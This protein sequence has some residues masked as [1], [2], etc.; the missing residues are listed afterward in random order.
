MA[1]R[2]PHSSQSLAPAPA[3]VGPAR[4]TPAALS[5]T[6]WSPRQELS[7]A[8]WVEQGRWL[9]ALGRGSG[10]WL[11][12]WLR[13]GTA[14]YGDK[15]RPAAA[16][17]GYDVQSL[18]NMAWVAGRFE[19]SRRRENLSF[20]HHAELAGL[21]PADQELWLDR[22]AAGGLSVRALRLEL[23]EARRR[24]ADRETL[25]EARRGRT[26]L[27]RSNSSPP[28]RPQPK[29][30]CPHCGHPLSQAGA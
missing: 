11:G 14:R 13:Y 24:V 19:L 6:S 21:P 3:S 18:M 10:W 12:D 30:V 16:V 7:V 9:G 27:A 5:S 29:P 17:T 4:R 8:D 26:P 23:R 1:P 2:P 28:R 22:A 25:R 15:Y 20:S